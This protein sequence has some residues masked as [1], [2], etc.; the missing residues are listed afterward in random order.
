MASDWLLKELQN[1]PSPKPVSKP[2]VNTP[3]Q[4]PTVPKTATPTA[5]K[6]TGYNPIQTFKTN[7]NTA[8]RVAGAG[9]GK[10]ADVISRPLYAFGSGLQGA[11]QG[12][13]KEGISGWAK[14]GVTGAWKGLIG[15]NKVTPGNYLTDT[16]LKDKITNP[17]AKAGVQ[18]ATDIVADPLN[19]MA[20]N[21]VRKPISAVA[22]KVGKVTESISKTKPVQKAIQFAKETP[23]IYKPIEAVVD[24]YFRNPEAGKIIEAAKEAI[25][26]RTS[27]L[28]RYVDEAQ[29]GLTSAEKARIGQILEGGVTLSK[30]TGLIKTGYQTDKKL[31]EIANKFRQMG[32][33]IGA[34]SVKTGLLT[35]ESFAKLK[36]NYMHH[37]WEVV[38]DPTVA[39]Q[40]GYSAGDL[41]KIDLGPFKK[42][43]GATGYVKEFQAPTFKGLGTEIRS[44]EAAKMYQELG[45]R[46]GVK[47]EQN[48]SV[49]GLVSD[50]VNQLKKEYKAPKTGL[51]DIPFEQT[52]QYKESL[53][54]FLDYIKKEV[55]AMT[56]EGTRMGTKLS[57]KNIVK[58]GVK[59][60]DEITG[61]GTPE[62]SYPLV[63]GR[64]AVGD[65]RKT[66][67]V[68]GDVGK[69]PGVK[70]GPQ[71]LPTE[72]LVRKIQEG[73]KYA[74]DELT[75]QKGAGILKDTALP[76]EVID[77][78]KRYQGTAKSTGGKIFDAAMNLWKQGKTVWNPA[79]HV[80]N[81]LSN[82]ILTE[83]QT[84]KGIPATLIDYANSVKQYL[85]K[86]NQKYFNEA[87]DSGLIKRKYF[88]EAVQDFLGSGM[89]KDKWYQK[90]AKVPSELQS[91]MEETAKL[92]I[93][94][95]MRNEGKTVQEAMKL[96]EEAIFS[97]YRI[98]QAERTFM[99]RAIPFYS[100][101][102]QAAPFIGKKLITHPER[103]TK[104][105]KAENAVESLT[106]PENEQYLPE[107]MKG[108]VRTPLKNKEGQTKYFNPQY[109]YPWGN[110]FNET[111]SNVA[112]L[113]FGFSLNPI[114]EELNA[115][116]LNKD[117]YFGTDIVKPG[118]PGG[119]KKKIEHAV[120]TFAPTLY[121]T[122]KEKVIPALQGKPDTQG[123]ERNLLDVGLGEF[124]GLK[125]YPFDVNSGKKSQSINR[126][127]II[128][129]AQDRIKEIQRRKDLT[130]EEKRK[131]IQE[132]LQFRDQRLQGK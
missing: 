6:P 1:T 128:K 41:P 62:Y 56:P 112:G 12:A 39:K 37:M 42:R 126:Y 44:N 89:N 71:Y 8:S 92:N 104:Y 122:V 73:F 32:E 130:I 27:Q 61:I 54:P 101:T 22:G 52:A 67:A 30:D 72:K 16:V 14:G 60:A 45:S 19:F 86:G 93:F 115:Q 69:I 116:R 117:A 118:E 58:K 129:D 49:S 53:L 40:F 5:P 29:K 78:I 63:Q 7:V 13:E 82:Q 108:M 26:S 100:F 98:G 66:E 38:S 105:I 50:L 76:K 99:G 43:T 68:L 25:R 77:Y 46:F 103:F 111:K 124:A 24:P 131:Q 127:V 65:L 33:E 74:P 23:A 123:R 70:T 80:R 110:F 3:T 75:F 113:P 106:K 84:G 15:E 81:F 18:F 125:T 36:G 51:G 2:V 120:R 21:E 107:W 47:A 91:F 109:I 87:V 90:L 31:V 85:G 94:S 88:G 97:P 17:Y 102:R 20:F 35:P 9:L 4:M 59:G 55:P 95:E 114:F 28:Y 64:K 11:Y 83:L 121:N 10:I 57:L 132:R 96:A 48:K 119:G 79:Y 34:E